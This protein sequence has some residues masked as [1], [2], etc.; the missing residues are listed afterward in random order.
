M[1]LEV[2]TKERSI[3]INKEEYDDLK[4]DS[5]LKEQYEDL[6]CACIGYATYRD[7]H[8]A[9]MYDDFFIRTLSVINPEFFE[10]VKAIAEEMN[11]LKDAIIEK[12]PTED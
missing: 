1:A 4:N 5:R 3:E 12:E 10:V 9:I 6:I 7:H 8:V 11:P 2:Y